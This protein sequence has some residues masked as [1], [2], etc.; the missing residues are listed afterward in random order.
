MLKDI[1][2]IVFFEDPGLQ[3]AFK[4]LLSQPQNK[5]LL[6]KYEESVPSWTVVLA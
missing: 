3:D 2:V 6:L 1:S 4:E 5:P